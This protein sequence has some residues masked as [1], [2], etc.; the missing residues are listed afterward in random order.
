MNSIDKI[1]AVSAQGDSHL[2]N[3][4]NPSTLLN[5]SKLAEINNDNNTT[6]SDDGST[7]ITLTSKTQDEIDKQQQLKKEEI[8]KTDYTM[9]LTGIPLYGGRLISITKYPNGSEEIIDTLSGQ[10]ITRQD[11]QQAISPT[12]IKVIEA[13]NNSE[14]GVE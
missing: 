2:S 9:E 6:S 4:D 1:S 12:E 14:S 8:K 3:G 13:N 11:L 10:R 5:N 7:K